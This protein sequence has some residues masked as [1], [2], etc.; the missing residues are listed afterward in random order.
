MQV[1]W[2]D[3]F[4]WGLWALTGILL[5]PQRPLEDE[6]TVFFVILLKALK[7]SALLSDG[8]LL[9]PGGRQC[10][11]LKLPNGDFSAM[12]RIRQTPRGNW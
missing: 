12:D 3:W 11:L 6:N 1:S 5:L 10:L 2:L 8:R 4:G 7:R 9:T